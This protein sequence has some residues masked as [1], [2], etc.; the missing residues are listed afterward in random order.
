MANTSEGVQFTTGGSVENASETSVPLGPPALSVSS[1]VVGMVIGFTGTCANAVVFVVL[2]FARRHF[3]SHV[4]TLIA[5]QSAMD[6]VACVC[7]SVSI[8]LSFPG[9]PRN[10]MVLG[11]VGNTLVCFLFRNRVLAIVCMNAEKIGLV[12][13]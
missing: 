2:V 3:G 1:V 4:N 12:D 5:N 10:Y 11:D 9:A 13:E 6:L 7:L 8:G